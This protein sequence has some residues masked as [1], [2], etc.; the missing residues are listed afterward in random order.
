MK[1]HLQNIGIDGKKVVLR[2]DFNVPIKGGKILDSNKIDLSLETIKYLLEHNCSIVI[3]SHFGRVKTEDDKRNNTLLPVAD[4]LSKT[5]NTNVMFSTDT[6]SIALDNAVASMKPKEILLLENTRFEDISGNLESGNDAQ[7]AAYWAS[8]GE[9]F[10]MD[11]FASA[12]RAHASTVGITKFLPSCMG[13]LMQKELDMLEKLTVNLEKPFTVMMGGAKI[14]DKL[15][16]L[17]AL[18]PR[19]D[20]LL[21]SGGLANTCLKALGFYVAS[22]LVSN[23]PDILEKIKTLMLN[24]RNKIMLPLDAIV[25][26]TYNKDYAD[27]KLI[28]EIETDDVIYDIGMKTI[29]KY[30]TAIDASKTIFVNGTV[31]MYEDTKFA[32]GTREVLNVL[33]KC[34]ATVVIGGGDSVSAVTNLG[35][36]GKFANICSGGGATLEYLVKASLP[37]IDA[38]EEE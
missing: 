2:S 38:I 9:I 31:G 30:K 21:L 8:L 27:Y 12:H 14:E 22:S 13:F 6:R 23:D 17:D 1:K 20:Y 25:G 36:K 32:N 10:V 18:V 5:L 37:G 3:L 33:A 35:F 7:L 16:L 19:C 29:D 34:S 4:Y 11:A 24:N 15:E 26:N 28:N